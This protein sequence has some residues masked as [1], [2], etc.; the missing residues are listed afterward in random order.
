MHTSGVFIIVL[1]GSRSKRREDGQRVHSF[2]KV[3]RGHGEELRLGTMDRSYEKDL[4]EGAA[5]VAVE[6]PGWKG[7]MQRG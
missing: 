7:T 3:Q 2:S 5:L 1:W 4:G 6:D